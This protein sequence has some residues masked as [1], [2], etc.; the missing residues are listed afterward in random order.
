MEVGKLASGASVSL[1]S[2]FRARPQLD[3]RVAHLFSVGEVSCVAAQHGGPVAVC[4]CVCG[5]GRMSWR[6]A[7]EGAAERRVQ[8]KMG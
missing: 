3:A 2:G 8:E 4:V 6:L 7:I 5:G 1:S